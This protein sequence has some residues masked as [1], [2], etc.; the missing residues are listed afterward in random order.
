[1]RLHTCMDD[2]ARGSKQLSFAA[3]C[4]AAAC[5][6]SFA[7]EWEEIACADIPAEV[8]QRSGALIPLDVAS[9]IQTGLLGHFDA[10]RNAGES[11]P[12]DAATRA[13]K[14]LVAGQPD[15]AFNTENGYWTEDGFVFTGD[16][17]A[18]VNAPGINVGGQFMTIQLATSVDWESQTFGNGYYSIFFGNNNNDSDLFF[19]SASRNHTLIFN[20]DNWGTR[21]NRPSIAWDGQYATA[22]LGNGAS[23]LVQGTALTDG[24]I[25]TNTTIPARNYCWGGQQSNAKYYVKGIFHSVRIYGKAL[26]EEELAWN[27]MLDEVRYRGADTNIN[28]IV[29]SNVEGVEATERN[30]RYMV[31]GQHVF[32]APASVTAGYATYVPAGYT[33]EVWNSGGNGWSEAETHDG[34][35]SF[36]YTNCL[37]RAKVR[38]TWN[39]TIE[40]VV[41]EWAEITHDDIPDEVSQRFGALIPLGAASYVQTGLKGH[42]DAIRNAGESLP[43]DKSARTWKNLVAGQPDAAF[44]TEKG[45]WTEDG[46]VFTG[47][48]HASVNAPGINVGGQFMTVQLATTVD[49]E[50]QT[51]GSGRY[52]I[53]FGNDENDT[54]IYFNSGS[55]NRTLILNADRWGTGG[56]RPTLEWDGRYATAVLG[57]GVS[58]LVQDTALADGK[59]RTN[60]AIPARRFCWGGQQNNANYY[61]KGVFHSVRIYGKALSEEELAWNRMLDEV[62]YR[63][64]DTN[65]NVTV[66]SNTP[67]VGG[68]EANG[69]YMVNGHY[70]FTAPASVTA[71]G[72]TYTLAGYNLEEW[73]SAKNGWG[74][75]ETH[76]G[77]STFD[78]TN[79]LARAK[80]RLTW[81]WKM[82]SGVKP[83]DVDDYVQNDLVCHFDGIRNAGATAPHDPNATVWRNLI[84]GRPDATI[85]D[86]AGVWKDGTGYWFHGTEFGKCAQL[87]SE[88]ALGLSAT[89]QLAMDFSN[90]EQTSGK[91]SSCFHDAQ[92]NEFSIYTYGKEAKIELKAQAY[93]GLLGQSGRPSVVNWNGKYIT[94]AFDAEKCYFTSDATLGSG[95]AR[96]LFAE[97]PGRRFVWGCSPLFGTTFLTR[98][99]YHSVRI[100]N[101][102]LTDE[103]LRH[104]RAIDDVRFF[105]RMADLDETDVVLVRSESCDGTVK[106]G[107]EGAYI[108]RNASITFTAPEA[109]T[110]GARTFACR[111]YRLET[112]NATARQ[113]MAGQA[114]S[115]TSIEMVGGSGAANRRLTWIWEMTSGLRTA[116]D[117][118]VRDYVQEGLAGHFDG[119]SNYGVA[120]SH[121][122]TT[123]RWTNLVVDQPDATFNTGKGRW[124]ENGNGFVFT[125]DVHASVE[126]PGIDVGGENMSIQ[127][128]TSVDWES[129]TFGNGYYSIFFGNNNNDS[130]LFFSSGSRNHTLIFNADNWGTRD[131]RPSIAWDGQYATAILGN[132]ASY[133]VQGTALT[134]GMIRTNTSIPAR[135]YCWGGQQSN[136]KYYVKGAFHSV[137]IYNRALTGA[138]LVQNR[139][140]DD[141]RFRN[142]FADYA[143]L[144][145]VNGAVGDTETTGSSSL[146]SGEYELKGAL[147]V[148][149]DAVS[150]DGKMY[151]P[152]LAV[153]K[154]IDGEWCQIS[155]NWVSSYTATDDGRVRLKWTWERMMGTLFLV[156]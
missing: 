24:M 106:L 108:V 2:V 152:R 111:G 129:Q 44:N 34:E 137:R 119:I 133:L 8:S 4:A 57:D 86:G 80:V 41:D 18:S 75:V 58:Y 136:A 143:N 100:Y 83:V 122:A 123:R 35:T 33:L 112:W 36:A 63:G 23:Y 10:I 144:I 32:T 118:T 124:S 15:A 79:C 128:A 132:G 98:C 145:V 142:A 149:A 150:V 25:R 27:R 130:D 71:N 39:W 19:S 50:S 107:D 37:A 17:H 138:E 102:V 55:K 146:A 26:S 120:H 93:M 31:N 47:D 5:L 11:L 3:L 91:Y 28:V 94:T 154:L 95:M 90:D 87:D 40:E 81:N 13:W 127:L 78:Y 73:D 74:A 54:D 131:N 76:A 49:W 20:A 70:T 42:F 45:Y 92:D 153:E 88:I 147:T 59:P 43:H 46:F 14:N 62:R 109:Q 140:V 141:I 38:L 116:A 7:D 82:A 64:A 96:V 56:N 99:A 97:V 84:E 67:C 60:T 89:I 139:K 103:E 155:R 1:M 126:S 105:G 113:W 12:H 29:A 151:R 156:R 104:N 101:R 77:E 6:P 52:S 9:Y 53:F 66:G 51:F 135:N 68:A 115:G 65:I 117:Y 16:V 125:G 72:C 48:V 121:N 22:I 114:G 110:I 30:G 61:V 85:S 69:M 134:D 148:T 21:N